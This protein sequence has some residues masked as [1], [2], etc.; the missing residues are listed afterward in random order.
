MILIAGRRPRWTARWAVAVALSLQ[1]LGLWHAA[2]GQALA[3]VMSTDARFEIG[4]A[5]NPVAEAWNPIRLELRDMAPATLTIQ[6]DQGTLRSG[7][8]PLVVTFDVRGGAGLS[9]F[10]EIVYLPRFAT[11]SWRLAT[12]ERVLASGSI[13]GREADDRRLDLVLTSSPGVYRLPFLAAFG[14]GSRLVD[15]NPAALPTQP[16]AYDGVRGLLIDGTAAAP[17]LEAVAAALAGGVA[18]VLL[19]PL[20]SS[21]DEIAFLLEGG[22][23][24]RLGAGAV[25]AVEGQPEAAVETL[26]ALELP[27]RAALQAELVRQP[28]VEAPTPLKETTLV[29]VVAGFAVAVLL[30][31]RLGGVP[32]LSAALALAGM[33][34][35]VA[36]QLLRPAQPQL[37]GNA[38]LAVAGGE[39]ATLIPVTELLTM[40]R[41]S[42]TLSARAR[43]MQ[44]HAYWVDAAGTHLALDRWRS[45]LLELA[46]E[47]GEAQLVWRDGQP[48]NRG[49]ATL[50]ELFVVGEGHLGDL[51]PGS[52]TPVVSEVG[53]GDWALS[54]AAQV[55]HGSVLARSGC[56]TA[57]TTWVLYPPVAVL[58]TAD[59]ASAGSDPATDPFRR[60][61]PAGSEGM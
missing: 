58:A 52:S 26:A 61:T 59:P 35:L 48:Y 50:Q 49:P 33:A 36:W 8:V 22:T 54:L 41:S 16:A 11:L 25:V 32:G 37:E 3:Q 46:P 15:L 57:C 30:L 27:N 23:A 53:V 29:L 39:L 2:S 19:G 60:A 28:L 13:A 5:G 44:P 10:E 7:E 31:M 51:P 38:V 42:I 12:A 21:H 4:V 9:I 45:V 14:S 40:P 34:S 43:P 47:V 56:A 55:P 6:V 17:R 18:V 24:A 20:P 1:L